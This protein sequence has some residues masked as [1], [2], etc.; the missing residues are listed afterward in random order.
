MATKSTDIDWENL[1]MEGT[2]M[3]SILNGPDCDSCAG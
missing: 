3:C 2:K 1:D